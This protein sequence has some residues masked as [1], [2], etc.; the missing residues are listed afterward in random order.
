MIKIIFLTILLLTNIYS[1]EEYTNGLMQ[2]VTIDIDEL[3][4]VDTQTKVLKDP[5]TKWTYKI[6]LAF[7]YTYSNVAYMHFKRFRKAKDYIEKHNFN[8]SPELEFYKSTH[9]D[10]Q[11]SSKNNCIAIKPT[12]SIF[13]CCNKKQHRRA[14]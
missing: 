2:D 1:Q 4:P 12:F 11:H 3:V 7:K 10:K 9:H 14:I 6:V 13:K 5:Y 8:D